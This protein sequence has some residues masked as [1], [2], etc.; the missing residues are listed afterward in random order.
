MDYS[1]LTDDIKGEASE[2]SPDQE[3]LFKKLKGWFLFDYEK[4]EKWREEARE[5][6]AF[7]SGDQLSETDKQKLR[8]M[9]RPIIVMN[10]VEPIIDS[11]SGSEVANRQEVQFIP[12][13]MGAVQVNEVLTSAAKWFRDQCDAEDEESDAFREMVVCG[14]G[15]TE[16]RLDYEDDPDGAPKIERRD[17]LEMVWDST[18]KKRNLVDMRRLFHVCRDIPIEE[19]RAL[20]P[21]NDF[22]DADYNASW[23]DRQDNKE[24]HENN[25]TFYNKDDLGSGEEADKTVTMV[26]AQ[27]WERVPV[28]R[29]QDPTNPDN[30]LTLEKD[31]F[32]DLAKKAKLAGAVLRFAKQTRKV[33]KQ[34]YLGAILLEIGE[35]PCKDH[36]SFKAMTGKRDRNKNTWYGLMRAMKDAARW[37]NKWMS[38]TMHIMNTSAK[39]G[40]MAERGNFFENDMDGEESYAKQD[41]VTYLKSGALS[42]PNAKFAEKPQ[43]QFPASTFQL[44]QFAIS[45]LR[46]VT[47]VNVEILGQQQ[48]ADQAASLDLQRKQS[49]MIIL[50]PLFDSLRR[51]R[52]EQGRLLLYLIENYLSDGR[53]IRIVGQDQAQYVPLVRQPGVTTYDVI[54]DES[55]SS[56]N[57]KEATWSML[58]QILPVIGA[59]LPAA[60]WLALLKYSPLP[61]SAQKDISDSILKSQAQTQQ[62]PDPEAAK[63]AAELQAMNA[64]AQSEIANHQAL[65]SAKIDAMTR[66]AEA[67]NQLELRK[68]AA[69]AVKT[70]S[71]P[72]SGPNGEAMPPPPDASAL[73]MA[74]MHEFQIGMKGIADAMSAPKQIIKDHNGDPIGVAP[75]RV[76]SRE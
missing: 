37:S 3:A 8:D 69:E 24:P 62:K 41:T 66:E 32:D 21:N 1:S 10:R 60:T 13:T 61:T 2:A 33:F 75:M 67:K 20:C 51:Y 15:W 43:A 71:Q 11:V 63:A 17:P 22:E 54:V 12:R 70:M 16:T 36:F 53:L 42:G 76:G 27:W 9:N 73:V 26:R 72:Q 38:Q 57:Q 18:A 68:A 4:Q 45:S 34:A 74:M 48:G 49:A 52:K 6:F 39:G 40:I 44:M 64:K 5:D 31:A 29:V 14:M 35:A 25:N 55:P 47:G 23:V 28:W 30:I 46:D 58:Q 59:M 50:Q 19:A 7:T 65:T 56:P